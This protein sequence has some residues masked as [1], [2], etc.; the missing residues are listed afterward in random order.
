MCLTC[1]TSVKLYTYFT[2]VDI[3]FCK[4]LINE[5]NTTCICHTNI[6]NNNLQNTLSLRAISALDKLG[7]IPNRRRSSSVNL[8][9]LIFFFPP[10]SRILP[11]APT[12]NCS[13]SES[14]ESFHVRNIRPLYAFRKFVFF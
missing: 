14:S 5:L 10:L 1:K 12:S 7:S 4:Q 9:K 8:S 6:F 3:F 11:S 2:H 13:S